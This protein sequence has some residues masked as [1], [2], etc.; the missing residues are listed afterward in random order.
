MKILTTHS[1]DANNCRKEWNEFV[2]LLA[3]NQTLSERNHIL[4]FFKQSRDLSIFIG[5][6]FS[7]IK[8]PDVFAHEYEI[9][10]DFIADLVIGDSVTNHYLLVEFED[11]KP[12]SIFLKKGNKSTPDWSPRI[13]AAF[14]QL[15]DWLWKLEDM[16]STA[17]FQNTFGTRRATF[18]GLI[19]IGKDMNLAP[20]EADRL[21][22]RMDRTMIDSNPI[23]CIS[24]NQLSEDLNFYLTTRYNV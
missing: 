23:S 1:F 9:Y 7:K 10:R 4:P 5:E 3:Q 11:G 22:W 2:Q 24:F 18:E 21:K 20:Q 13:E 15:V 6:F 17:D 12:E 19:I 8:K 14:S 16:R